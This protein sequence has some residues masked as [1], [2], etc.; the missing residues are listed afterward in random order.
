MKTFWLPLLSASLLCAGIGHTERITT[1]SS[2]QDASS[3]GD[4]GC[5]PP[6]RPDAGPEVSPTEDAGTHISFPD[7]TEMRQGD[8]SLDGSAFKA[9]RVAMEDLKP[10]NRPLPTDKMEACFDDESAY[11]LQEARQS[12]LHQNRD[13]P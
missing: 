13:D 8:V 6:P 4:A 5:P 12:L 1:N 10:R 7:P 2:S 3:R 11:D 9:I